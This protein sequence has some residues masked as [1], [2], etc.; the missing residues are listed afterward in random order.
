MMM[1]KIILMIEGLIIT[2]VAACTDSNITIQKTGKTMGSVTI[3][4]R[5]HKKWAINVKKCKTCHHIGRYH[6]SC[7]ET[8]CHTDSK[9]FGQ[10]NQIHKTCLN[11]CHKAIKPKAPM[12][13]LDKR[14]HK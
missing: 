1:N 9:K 8:G 5:K 12:G 4:H 7:S 10:G 2:I 11:K 3:N 13:C 14:C 6:Q